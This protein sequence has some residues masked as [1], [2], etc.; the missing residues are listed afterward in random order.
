LTI[1]KED[2]MK[3]A[4]IVEYKFSSDMFNL[5]TYSR[6]D[7]IKMVLRDVGFEDRRYIMWLML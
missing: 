4:S 2:D 7:N 1:D 5:E 6:E 3:N